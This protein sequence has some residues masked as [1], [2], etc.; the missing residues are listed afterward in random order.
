MKPV[1]HYVGEAYPTGDGRA[2]LRPIDHPNHDPR[3]NVSN[4]RHVRTSEVMSWDEITGR[5]E[6]A[7]TLYE[8]VTTTP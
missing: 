2:Y 8:P 5:I 4:T 6:T 7:F 3:H 1:V